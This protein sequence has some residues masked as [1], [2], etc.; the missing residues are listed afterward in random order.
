M[1]S[2][3]ASR[4]ARRR[5]F[6]RLSYDTL[7]RVFYYAGRDCGGRRDVVSIPLLA[8][9]AKVSE[10]SKAFRAAFLEACAPLRGSCTFARS[11]GTRAALAEL[12]HPGG[13][14]QLLVGR[15]DGGVTISVTVENAD[16]RHPFGEP[17]D[18]HLVSLRVV[19]LG[20]CMQIY[21]GVVEGG[22]E[23]GYVRLGVWE[24]VRSF[25]GRST[26]PFYAYKFLPAALMGAD[27][28]TDG[29]PGLAVL[30][31]DPSTRPLT[32]Q[33][34]RTEDFKRCPAPSM[35]SVLVDQAG[36]HAVVVDAAQIGV[37]HRSASAT[38]N[39]TCLAT[40]VFGF[41]DVAT[42]FGLH[43][44][45]HHMPDGVVPH[46]VVRLLSRG[47]D[48]GV[49]GGGKTD[50]TVW[51]EFVEE[52][53]RDG[54]EFD[55]SGPF[56]AC[57]DTERQVL[58]WDRLPD[59]WNELRTQFTTCVFPLSQRRSRR[60][61][62]SEE[63]RGRE[64]KRAAARLVT[65]H[66]RED[67]RINARG[68]EIVSDD[69]DDGHDA[70]FERSRGAWREEGRRTREEERRRRRVDALRAREEIARDGRSA[71]RK[72]ASRAGKGGVRRWRR[73]KSS[74]TAGSELLAG[75]WHAWATRTAR[76][77]R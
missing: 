7:E 6:D 74:A 40:G 66:Y 29:V 46:S 10:L 59:A 42:T 49:G 58:D 2:R 68:C 14:R 77:R 72:A 71:R 18:S 31:G 36:E 51:A 67:A 5:P 25:S 1:A 73:E 27:E 75:A 48:G 43:A 60:G 16:I 55:W 76:E 65:A 19:M 22:R 11:R 20:N 12:R 53:E 37:V 4:K 3:E 15:I 33:F 35:L 61:E 38:T 21:C 62:R 8:H 70:R 17:V 41:R 44:R 63:G 50:A 69:S 9:A 34:D 57:Y 26:L 13:E 28:Q 45:G 54:Y 32:R 23:V 64:A 47:G 39:D 52:V 24:A 56:R 30:M